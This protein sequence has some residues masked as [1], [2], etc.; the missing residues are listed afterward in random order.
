MHTMACLM[1]FETSALIHSIKGETVGVFFLL[2][3]DFTQRLIPARQA[4]QKWLIAALVW[5]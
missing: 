4:M 3:M 5:L 1:Q 2:H